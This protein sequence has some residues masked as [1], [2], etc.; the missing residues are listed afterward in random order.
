MT[1][2]ARS[3]GAS[4]SN[5]RVE[6]EA[7]PWH[8]MVKHIRSSNSNKIVEINRDIEDL[9]GDLAQPSIE[10]DYR[11]SSSNQRADVSSSLPEEDSSDES[12]CVIN[13]GKIM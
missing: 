3:K 13:D 2:F 5:E 1:R 7:T 9:D 4:A 8:Q 10:E 12:D 11:H 6:E